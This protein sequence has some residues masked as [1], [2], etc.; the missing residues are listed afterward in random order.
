MLL[1]TKSIAFIA[2]FSPTSH[3]QIMLTPNFMCV[4][5]LIYYN[6]SEQKTTKIRHK[7]AFLEK[8]M[9]FLQ[10]VRLDFKREKA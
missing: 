5:K 8:E 3:L 2:H 1:P 4:K 6:Q 10:V 7:I 9:L